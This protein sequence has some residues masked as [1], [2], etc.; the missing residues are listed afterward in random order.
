MKHSRKLIYIFLLLALLAGCVPVTA[1]AANPAPSAGQ[2]APAAAFPV[3]IEHKFGSTT[4]TKAPERIVTVGLTEQDVL[5]ALGITPVGTT[6]W[7]GKYPSAVWP[8]AQDKLGDAKP[9]VVGDAST[10]NFEKIAALKPDLI[11]ALYSGVTQEQYDLLVKIAPTVLPP[12]GYVDYGIPWQELTRT[13]GR[14]VGK[15]AAADKLVT[16][17]EAR[18]VQVRT[19]HPEFVGATAVVA[20]PY[21]GVWVY[22]SQDVRGRLLTALGFKLPDGINEI[23][24]KEFGG[25]LS[26]ERADLL[27]VAVIIWLDADEAKGPLGGPLYAS[28]DVHTKGREVFLSSYTDPVGGA[29]SFVSVL[30]LPFL[31]DKLV[32]QLAT[33]IAK[34]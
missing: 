21:E 34:K 18:F 8:W 20:T 9:E 17:V 10:I 29:T 22:G 1:P 4:I 25:N 5:L 23:T 16:G 7:F 3:T 13:V 19:E 2:A 6:E 28:L 32:P 33:A 15:A 30:S 11:L 26:L 31:L 14:A 27:N 24:G 12:A